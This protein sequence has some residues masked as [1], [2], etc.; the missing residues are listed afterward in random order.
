MR[1]N[2]VIVQKRST[3]ILLV[4]GAA[5]RRTARYD[6]LFL[7]NYATLN[8]VDELKRMPGVGDVH[9][10]GAR[11][12][13][14]RIWLQPDRMAQLGVTPTDIANAIRAQNAQYAA[15]KIGAEPAPPG[16]AL[17]YTVTARGRLV[18]PE[19]F[20]NIVLRASGPSGVLRIKDVARVELGA[21][22]YDAAN[23]R[24]RQAGDRHRG[25]PADRRQRARRRRGGAS[26]RMVELKRPLSRRASTTSFRSTRRASSRRRSTKWSS[27]S[28]MPRCS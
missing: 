6:T 23:T 8:V 26:A 19:E 20:G 28:S 3:D 4:I 7:S 16:Q 24:R 17:I 14:M 5:R 22:S 15:G 9:V 11:D 18:E 2:G 25:V 27:R 10:F 13:S 21:Q 1:R 12:Y